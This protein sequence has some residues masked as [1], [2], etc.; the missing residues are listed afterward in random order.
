MDRQENFLRLSLVARNLA[1][2]QEVASTCK[3]SGAVEVTVSSDITNSETFFSFQVLV[4]QKDLALEE[5]C[6]QAVAETVAQYG[7]KAAN[8][9]WDMFSV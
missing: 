8:I 1:S 9:L 2:L 4:L 7:G 3:A 5:S 6:I